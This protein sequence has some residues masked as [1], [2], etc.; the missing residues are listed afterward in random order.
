[1]D[2]TALGNLPQGDPMPGLDFTAAS[3]GTFAAGDPFAGLGDL[4]PADPELLRMLDGG[5]ERSAVEQGDVEMPDSPADTRPESGAEQQS[6]PPPRQQLDPRLLESGTGRSGISPDLRARLDAAPVQ[7]RGRI[8]ELPDT[9]V[10]ERSA[11]EVRRAVSSDGVLISEATLRIRQS[12]A[13]TRATADADW[14]RL[15]HDVDQ[16]FNRPNVVLP[17]GDVLRVRVLRAGAGEEPHHSVTLSAAGRSDQTSWVLGDPNRLRAIGSMLGLPAEPDVE[18]SLMGVPGADGQANLR[19]RHVEV[20]GQ[21]IG[22]VPAHSPEFQEPRL[23]ESQGP[24]A[25]LRTAADLMRRHLN[26]T[27]HRFPGAELEQFARTVRAAGSNSFSGVPLHGLRGAADQAEQQLQ[28][29]RE[30]AADELRGGHERARLDSEKGLNPITFHPDGVPGGA[31]SRPDVRFGFELEMQYADTVRGLQEAGSEAAYL[32]QWSSKRASNA[33]PEFQAQLSALAQELRQTGY[34]SQDQ[35]ERVLLDP[36]DERV[37]RARDEGKWALVEETAHVQGFELV[38][39]ILRPGAEPDSW[40]DVAE[41]MDLLH[42]H[43]SSAANTG[44]HVNVSFTEQLTP[45]EHVRLARIQKGFESVLYRLGNHPGSAKQRLMTMVGPGPLPADP[46]RVP[47]ATEVGGLNRDKAEGLS[48]RHIAGEDSDRHEFR[49]WAGTLDAG[50][51]QAHAELSAA[52]L[53]AAKDS[54]IDRA[55]DALMAEPKLLGRAPAGLPELADLFALLPLSPDAREQAVQLF[56]ATREWENTGSN[57][58]DH[59]L[60][61][62]GIPQGGL[63]Y[64]APGTSVRSAVAQARN[65][66]PE[67]DTVDLLVATVRQD[68]RIALWDGGVLEPD[69]FIESATNRNYGQDVPGV[70][71]VSGGGRLD[72]LPDLVEA[73]DFGIITTDAQVFHTPDG[74]IVTGHPVVGADGV[75]RVQPDPAGWTKHDHEGAHPSGQADLGRALAEFG[76]DS[77]TSARPDQG[78]ITEALPE[79]E[80]E[81]GSRRRPAASPDEMDV[82]SSP[83]ETAPTPGW[84]GG[85]TPAAATPGWG[86]DTVPWHGGLSTPPHHAPTPGYG[87][88]PTPAAAMD[89]DADQ[90]M[91]SIESAPPEE[92]VEWIGEIH[93]ADPSRVPDEA[94]VQLRDEAAQSLAA[95]LLEVARGERKPFE[96]RVHGWF[97]DAHGPDAS[98]QRTQQV[99]DG[100]RTSLDAHLAALQPQRPV[101]ALTTALEALRVARGSTLPLAD[102]GNAVTPALAALPQGESRAALDALDVVLRDGE[103]QERLG[104]A[105]ERA[106]TALAAEVRAAQRHT[107]SSLGVRIGAKSA[108]SDE[109]TVLITSLETEGHGKHWADGVE[110]PITDEAW[111]HTEVEHASWFDPLWNKLEPAG[112]ER[113]RRPIPDATVQAAALDLQMSSTV[114][115][116]DPKSVTPA[117]PDSA[118]RTLKLNGQ[119]MTGDIRYDVQ[120]IEVEP[121]RFVQERTFKAHLDAESLL[122]THRELAER[123]AR[124]ATRAEERALELDNAASLLELNGKPNSSR[125]R[126]ARAQADAAESHATKRRAKADASAARLAE[127]QKRIKDFEDRALR[128]IDEVH[129]TGFRLPNGDQFHGRLVFVDDP[130]QAHDTVVL[131]EKAQMDQTAWNVDDDGSGIAHEIGHFWGLPDEYR[132]PRTFDVST[133]EFR[134]KQLPVYTVKVHLDTDPLLDSHQDKADSFQREA[135]EAE[136]IAQFDQDQAV[137]LEASLMDDDSGTPPPEVVDAQA[138]AKLS[139]EMADLRYREAAEAKEKLN[140]VLAELN[141]FREQAV[142]GAQAAFHPSR[143]HRDARY[144]VEVEFVDHP[145]EAHLRKDLHPD[146]ASKSDPDLWEVSDGPNLVNAR[147]GAHLGLPP[148]YLTALLHGKTGNLRSHPKDDRRIFNRDDLKLPIDPKTGEPHLPHNS[149]VNDDG[150]MT[151]RERLFLPR[152]AWRVE[153]IGFDLG[154]R[155]DVLQPGPE[156]LARRVEH[157]LSRSEA[158]HQAPRPR[159]KGLTTTPPP[160]YQPTRE[161]SLMSDLRELTGNPAGL[162]AVRTE[163]TRLTGQDLDQVVLRE[164]GQGS[165]DQLHHLVAEH[166]AAASATHSDQG[167]DTES[168]SSRGSGN[169]SDSDVGGSHGNRPSGATGSGPSLGDLAITIPDDVRTG[170]GPSYLGTDPTAAPETTP[171]LERTHQVQELLPRNVVR[172]E[173]IDGTAIRSDAREAMLQAGVPPERVEQVLHGLSDTELKNGFTSLNGE[174]ITVSSGVGDD[175]VEVVV[176]AR[177][178]DDSTGGEPAPPTT[179]PAKKGKENKV[180]NASGGFG[181]VKNSSDSPSARDDGYAYRGS[182]PL[183]FLPGTSMQ[184]ALSLKGLAPQRSWSSTDSSEVQHGSTVEPGG[185]RTRTLHDLAHTA[186][187]LRNGQDPVRISGTGSGAVTVSTPNSLHG[188]RPAEGTAEFDAPR[189]GDSTRLR[190][191]RAL[192]DQARELVHRHPAWEGKADEIG[193]ALRGTLRGLFG[194]ASLS[195]RDVDLLSG[196]TLVEQLATID[197]DGRDR[198]ATVELKARR[199]EAR[200]HLVADGVE[201]KIATKSGRKDGHS[202][203]STVEQPVDLG[204]RVRLSQTIWGDDAG[205][206]IDVRGA[207]QGKLTSHEEHGVTRSDDLRTEL[208]WERKGPMRIGTGDLTYDLRIRFDDGVVEDGSVDVPA[209][210]TAWRG[211]RPDGTAPEFTG[212]DPFP[213]Q[214]VL[215]AAETRFPNVDGVAAALR[216]MLPEGVLPPEEGN[217]ESHA[218]ENAAVL[219]DAVSESGFSSRSA[220]LNGPGTSFVLTRAQHAN[221]ATPDDLVGVLVET[222]PRTTP[223]YGTFVP[224]TP[225]SSPKTVP[226]AELGSELTGSTKVEHS[227]ASKTGRTLGTGGG[228]RGRAPSLGRLGGL[229]LNLQRNDKVGTEEATL[230][231]AGGLGRGQGWKSGDVV[232]HPELIDYRVTVFGAEGVLAERIVE[233][234]G[235]TTYA[236]G[237]LAPAPRTGL[238][239]PSGSYQQVSHAAP[240]RPEGWEPAELPEHFVVHGL[241]LPEVNGHRITGEMFGGFGDNKVIAG[242]QVH[243]FVSPEEVA[244]NF[245]AVATGAYEGSVHRY[246]KGVLQPSEQRLG[247]V[248]LHAA[249]SNARLNGPPQ[250]VELTFTRKVTGSTGHGT[251]TFTGGGWTARARVGSPGSGDSGTAMPVLSGGDAESGSQSRSEAQEFERTT[252][253]TYKGP[254]YLVTY[255]TSTLLSGSE[256]DLPGVHLEAHKKGSVQLWVPASEIGRIGLGPKP[257]PAEGAVHAPPGIDSDG[258]TTAV[259]R[260]EVTERLL[261]GIKDVLAA[262][263]RQDVPRS[264]LRQFGDYLTSLALGDAERTAGAD[265]YRQSARDVAPSGLRALLSD[266]RGPGKN[267]T[268]SVPGPLGTIDVSLT[269]KGEQGPGKFDGIESGWSEKHETKTTSSVTET[270][271]T[272]HQRKAQPMAMVRPGGDGPQSR[273]AL[274]GQVAV[275]SK[276]SDKL[277]E[278]S[279]T[280]N[281]RTYSSKSD[282]ATFGHDLDLRLEV[283]KTAH[284]NRTPSTLTGGLADLG[285]PASTGN[286]LTLPT[287]RDAVRTRVPVGELGV[288]EHQPQRIDELSEVSHVVANSDDVHRVMGDL[289]DGT[290]GADGPPPVPER[291]TWTRHGVLTGTTTSALSAHLPKAMGG[292]GYRIGGLDHDSHAAEGTP[293]PL[294]ALVLTAELDDAHVISTGDEAGMTTK[295]SRTIAIKEQHKEGPGLGFTGRVALDALADPRQAMD[296][297]GANYRQSPQATLPGPSYSWQRT[298]AADNKFKDGQSEQRSAGETFLVSAM[299]NWTITPE[300]RA[301]AP[302]GWSE[303]RQARDRVYLHTDRA[304]LIAMGLRPPAPVAVKVDETSGTSTPDAAT[305]APESPKRD[306]PD[307]APT[308]EPGE[309]ARQDAPQEAERQQTQQEAEPEP[310]RT[311]LDDFLFP[312]DPEP[313]PATTP[314]SDVDGEALREDTDSDAESDTTDLWSEADSDARTEATDLDDTRSE[315]SDDA[316]DPRAKV[317]EQAQEAENALGKMSAKA[318]EDLFIQA[319][320]IVQP[321][322]QVP[323]V[324]DNPKPADV[325]LRALMDEVT[326]IVARELHQKGPDAA[327]ALAKE[328]GNELG[329][330]RTRGLLGGSPLGDGLLDNPAIPRH[331]SDPGPSSTS[332]DRSAE[333]PAESRSEAPE[334]SPEDT[335]ERA[336]DGDG[337]ERDGNS[338]QDRSA[339]LDSEGARPEDGEQ[340][341]EQDGA[342]EQDGEDGDGGA[343]DD[344][345]EGIARDTAPQRR[346]GLGLPRNLARSRGLGAGVQLSRTE[347]ADQVIAETTGSPGGLPR[348]DVSP[349]RDA[350]PNGEDGT[351]RAPAEDPALRSGDEPTLDPA[352]L[353]DP[354]SRERTR[355]T[356]SRSISHDWSRPLHPTPG[357]TP[358]VIEQKYGIITENQ[359]LFQEFVDQHGL[360]VDVR[361]TNPD[362]VRLL[363]EGAYPKP[364][365]IKAKTINRLDVRLGAPEHGLGAVGF[366]SPKLPENLTDADPDAAGLRDRARQRLTEYRELFSTMKDLAKKYWVEDGV[367]RTNSGFGEDGSPAR[368]VPVAGD[369]DVF[370]IRSADDGRMLPE[371]RYHEMV[372]GLIARNMGVQHGAHRYWNPHR[373]TFEATVFDTINRSHDPGREPLVRFAPGEPPMEV[374]ADL[375]D[376]PQASTDFAADM[377]AVTERLLGSEPESTSGQVFNTD[378]DP[379]SR[380]MPPNE[381]GPDRFDGQVK[382]A[383][384]A[385]AENLFSRGRALERGA[386]ESREV[387]PGT[388]LDGDPARTEPA[389]TEAGPSR[390]AEEEIRAEYE[391]VVPAELALPEA[392]LRE[393]VA[394][395]TS[396]GDPGAV[397]RHR[398][399]PATAELLSRLGQR[400]AAL[401]DEA[402]RQELRSLVADALLAATTVPVRTSESSVGRTDRAALRP[403]TP[404][405]LDQLLRDTEQVMRFGLDPLLTAGQDLAEVGYRSGEPAPARLARLGL[406]PLNSPARQ[407]TLADPLFNALLANPEALLNSWFGAT[408]NERQLFLN[409]C[410]SASVNSEIRASVPTLGALLQVGRGVADVT[411]NGLGKVGPGQRSRWENLT[412]RSYEDMV[413]SRVD[414]TKAVFDELRAEGLKMVREGGSRAEWAALTE[415]WARTMQK[416]SGA[417]LRETPPVLTKQTWPGKWALSAALALPRALDRPFRR[418]YGV[419]GMAYIGA[420]RT[421]FGLEPDAAPFGGYDAHIISA[422][423]LVELSDALATAEGRSEFWQRVAGRFGVVIVTPAHALFLRAAEQNGEPVFVLHDPKYDTA[424]KLSPEALAELA[425]RRSMSVSPHLLP[426]EDDGSS[427]AGTEDGP[428]PDDDDGGSGPDRGR[429]PSDSEDDGGSRPADERDGERRDDGGDQQESSDRRE[430]PAAARDEEFHDAVSDFGDDVFHDAPEAGGREDGGSTTGGERSAARPDDDL[431]L[432]FAD[433]DYPQGYGAGS[434]YQGYPQGYGPGSNYA[435]SSSGYDRPANPGGTVPVSSDFA[436]PRAKI[437]GEVLVGEGRR[438]KVQKLSIPLSQIDYQIMP[439]TGEWSHGISFRRRNDYVLTDK[440]DTFVQTLPGESP[441]AAAA[442]TT[443]PDNSQLDGNAFFVD[444]PRDGDGFT[445]RLRD[446]REVFVSQETL[447]AVIGRLNA[448]R[449]LMAEDEKLSVVVL[450]SPRSRVSGVL[451]QLRED[452]F[453]GDMLRNRGAVTQLADGRFGVADNEGWSSYGSS[454]DAR[455]VYSKGNVRNIRFFERYLPYA[456]YI[457]D[458]DQPIKVTDDNWKEY[459]IYPREVHPKSFTSRRGGMWRINGMSF[460]G[461]SSEA[462]TDGQIAASLDSFSRVVRTRPGEQI[463]SKITR[464]LRNYTPENDP[465]RRLSPLPWVRAE[466]RI[467]D[468][469]TGKH[470]RVRVGPA[471]LSSHGNAEEMTMHVK[472]GDRSIQMWLPGSAFLHMLVQLKDFQEMYAANP[473]LDFAVTICEAGAEG[474]KVLPRMMD[475]AKRF[476]MPNRF[477]TGADTISMIT[478]LDGGTIGVSNNKGWVSSYVDASGEIVRES[479]GYTRYTDDELATLPFPPLESGHAHNQRGTVPISSEYLNPDFRVPAEDES[480]NPISLPIAQIGYRQMG[481]GSAQGVSFNLEPEFRLTGGH[482]KIVATMPGETV[483]QAAGHELRP[484]HESALPKGEKFYTEA[485]NTDR[486]YRVPLIGGRHAF[487]RGDALGAVL[488]QIPAANGFLAKGANLALLADDVDADQ[489]LDGLSA[490]GVDAG[491]ISTT[492]KV[493]Q[494]AD[495]RLGASDNAG[496]TTTRAGGTTT[497]G[498]YSTGNVENISFFETYLPGSTH[499]PDA[500]APIRG[501]DMDGNPFEFYAHEVHRAGYTTDAESGSRPTAIDLTGTDRK[502]QPWNNPFKIFAEQV[503]SVHQVVRTRPGEAFAK[504]PYRERATLDVA[505]PKKRLAASPWTTIE[506]EITDPST[507]RRKVVNAGPN[508][509][510]GHGGAHQIGMY[511]H[512]DGQEFKVKVSGADYIRTLAQFPEFR[513]MRKA[514]PDSPYLLTVCGAGAEGGTTLSSAVDQLRSMSITNEVIAARDVLEISKAST[515]LAVS[516]NN[517]QGWVSSRLRGGAESQVLHENTRYT[518]DELRALRGGL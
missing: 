182:I 119:W 74:R 496:F 37:V 30:A 109:N 474:A 22:E 225:R 203:E 445:L 335:G 228:L 482:D 368:D 514:N 473:A 176:R 202:V 509:L 134:G 402:R 306:T 303:P 286:T 230:T 184:T 131:S 8:R 53:L 239:D 499:I 455:F 67:Y 264:A 229:D 385:A 413:R 159:P 416:L 305:S 163:F 325:E 198:T 129:N 506:V 154:V 296:A 186:T 456:E 512:R 314:E 315:L 143:M 361:P 253:T 146:G 270:G 16:R 373:A 317:R 60:Q 337:A 179:A 344:A 440:S 97:T 262:V 346:Q 233:G 58:R 439:S 493:G 232:S 265:L 484:G 70:L 18:G 34:L 417:S 94:A 471:L 89:L 136:D 38:S 470:K 54:S 140:E 209:A 498:K 157:L 460:V 133:R 64:P 144:F 87:D 483:E 454:R 83:Y 297:T 446:G 35:A 501:V 299:A 274:L 405:R 69:A 420:V 432:Q 467:T 342:R 101:A 244:V 247:N 197:A 124:I 468:L 77:E 21:H 80:P 255:D 118:V 215:G 3:N 59:R 52:M 224:A 7:Q 107:L 338:G 280:D 44:G 122:G 68:Q 216:E 329:T 300:Y 139:R 320:R 298:T 43:E 240:R 254:A 515:V 62:V 427:S 250:Q 17:N 328:L 214:H 155:A 450:S 93:D 46:S 292:G 263:P 102:L 397:E 475:T 359:R 220:A 479:Y 12:G 392:Q 195:R 281:T 149:Y 324:L 505:D 106:E 9:D 88:A 379:A 438:Q 114:S 393:R 436:N 222:V 312:R 63:L 112:W 508:M 404:D 503:D 241:D 289:L 494:L 396:M 180:D 252:T 206:R 423:K 32:A 242:H 334:Q 507:G 99:L 465:L 266:L 42:R 138:D 391:Q 476:R 383:L 73:T 285:A 257:E 48:F 55:L 301:G 360:V 429:D 480:G 65:V 251:E 95:E 309:S 162:D 199:G 326:T 171:L 188:L 398:L 411:L 121:G 57:D 332:R 235:S 207:V 168:N 260:P 287:L 310:P 336:A 347:G 275:S 85:E 190:G 75:L 11:F 61:T 339:R 19:V 382:A 141:E 1:M 71:A 259:V 27:A 418:A 384:D 51:T 428:R 345:V 156:R 204:G 430:D 148:K 165:L 78:R 13:V 389:E 142:R 352:L 425:G 414:G 26:T 477:Y 205:N 409:S 364:P 457:P 390:T 223:G 183:P 196:G 120:R 343:R 91:A 92:M 488:G 167:S 227:S 116:P 132:A 481:E 191:E 123:H 294:E 415:K 495:G 113:L 104:A 311:T 517:N 388:L 135:E 443:R 72:W 485:T 375:P 256:V 245:D 213:P 408:G 459:S 447:G 510:G 82:D 322:H 150:L 370:N 304:G 28:Q 489:V 175:A 2:G 283:R 386:L 66:S 349:S 451:D 362:S 194:S 462:K 516:V 126:S 238:A 354:P 350:E 45:A 400:I 211:E 504:G 365:E 273:G 234:G 261:A 90:P 137:Q 437:Y 40:R 49:F 177:L 500:D 453:T 377:N 291:A 237:L 153:Q 316:P 279:S 231:T 258:H 15:V 318:F 394:E 367:V 461:K 100:L 130:A 341:Q 478:I 218:T 269:L 357:L 246:E 271:K 20:L 178:D 449:S 358:E 340:V 169:D 431:A 111:R 442:H 406:L 200:E 278:T 293:H 160:R 158:E 79:T 41:L 458:Y 419:D 313:E 371:G 448:F 463:T 348:I 192:F 351:P 502:T 164:L 282:F 86:G 472:R 452:G 295:D 33:D 444:V 486:G 399:N 491:I 307:P 50:E 323:L 25:R 372:R 4:P 23:A 212:G 145:S 193:S 267:W 128:R 422:D 469:N 172:A 96:I 226:G 152:N 433:R 277:T 378:P 210:V 356:V 331:P 243:S 10:V 76:H 127:E 308:P 464:E 403:I 187:V 319:R 170:E 288:G 217:A 98:A 426:E 173:Q 395:L 24:A 236:G 424:A 441:A 387:S 272:G 333:P 330:R 321:L 31:S 518:D 466:H 161:M 327:T 363:K 353:A 81:R 248:K 125:V 14:A 29:I 181:K 302:E 249:L 513:E 421:Q 208:A 108:P 110:P 56:A 412:G 380:W 151:G 6:P 435:P 366:F 36:E 174:G 39:P 355:S 401:P 5:A 374:H 185:K 147:I 434:Y 115:K 117:L 376:V 105:L 103:S 511:V 219:A 189:P 497:H 407:A 487:L 490:Q 221:T 47:T 492:G 284:A 201:G 410:V 166:D 84:T 290:P 381:P 268:A 369:H 276:S